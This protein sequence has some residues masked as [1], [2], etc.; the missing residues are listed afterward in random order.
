[1]DWI[2]ALLLGVVEGVTEYL[3][4]SS[5]G[6]LILVQRL[7]GIG[8]GEAADAFAICIQA[9]AIAAVLGLYRGRIAQILRGLLGRDAAGRLLLVNLL[10]AFAPAV[11]LGLLL[12]KRIKAHLFNLPAITAA[13]LVG[14]LAILAA[15][16]WARREGR[17]DGKPLEELTTA[18]ALTIGFLQCVAM[19]PGTSRSLVTILG[20]LLAGLGVGP[21]VEF[22]FLLGVVTLS[23]ATAHD[24]WTHGAAMVSAYH[25]PSLLVGFAAA[26]VA[27]AAAVKWMVGYLR[28]HGLAVFGWYRILL[29][30]GAGGA[31]LT[32]RLVG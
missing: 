31:L 26:T 27:A 1:M 8:G 20:G 30:L 7:L 25:W 24:V 9:G 22:S 13:W 2:Q 15:S 29:A 19:W 11:V 32:G 4:V 23:A 16:R 28:R 10:Y 6:H 12:E 21:A 14:G 18:G 5:T 3:P 17:G